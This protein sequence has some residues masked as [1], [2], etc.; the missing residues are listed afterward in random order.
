TSN[1]DDN[2]I[3]RFN[4]SGSTAGLQVYRDIAGDKDMPPLLCSNVQSAINSMDR[5]LALSISN[6]TLANPTVYQLMAA[7]VNL[8][9][10]VSAGDA[11]LISSRSV[12]AYNCEFPQAGNYEWN[13]SDFVPT[14]AYVPSADWLFID[15]N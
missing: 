8:D 2:G 12:N 7:D 4:V 11:S 14:A 15:Q 6:F 3:L 10:K 5:N 13:G 1:A 9:G